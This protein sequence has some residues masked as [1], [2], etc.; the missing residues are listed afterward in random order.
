MHEGVTAV[1]RSNVD[2][3]FYVLGAQNENEVRVCVCVGGEGV[4]RC[5]C[6]RGGVCRCVCVGGEGC[7][8]SVMSGLL[9]VAHAHGSTQWIVWCNQS[10]SKV[11]SMPLCVEWK[12]FLLN[13]GHT[14]DT[15]AV[16]VDALPG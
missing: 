6:G 12:Q 14:R 16:W 15:L 2:L 10:D 5:V 8:H 9:A 4:C 13:V 1:Y 11:S 7:V 3:F